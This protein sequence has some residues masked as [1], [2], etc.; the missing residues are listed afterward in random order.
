MRAFD[1]ILSNSFPNKEIYSSPGSVAKSIDNGGP[2]PHMV[3]IRIYVISH[4]PPSCLFFCLAGPLTW[5]FLILFSLCL[6]SRLKSGCDYIYI[7]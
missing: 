2:D 4:V 3:D 6:V 7:G 1:E 5:G